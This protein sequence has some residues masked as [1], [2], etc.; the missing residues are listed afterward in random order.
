MLRV[1]TLHASSAA[2]TAMYYAQYL[3]AAPG[4]VP[5]M[6]VGQQAHRLGLTGDVTVK[7]LELLLSGRDPTSGTLLGRELLDRYRADGRVVRAVSG[8]DATFSAPKSVSVLWALT[9][10]QRFLE[11][12]DL[13]VAAALEHLERFGSTTRIRS[14]GARLHP[15]TNGL[16]LATFRQTT[17]RA[18][19]P[20]LHTH[21]VVSA[22]VQ[23]VDGRWWA[24]DARYLK[25]HQRM[26]GGLY[27]SVLRSELTAALGVEW[28]PIVNGQAD[29]AGVPDELLAVFSKR[30]AIIEHAMAVKLGEFRAR[31][32]R[33]PSRWERAVLEREASADT[34][35]RKTGHGA[36]DLVEHWRAEAEGVGWTASRL[37][38]AVEQAAQRTVPNKSISV[39]EVIEHLSTEHS[40]WGRA[41]VVRAVCDLLRPLP[42]VGGRRWAELVEQ[43]ADRVVGHCVDLDPTI[44]ARRRASDG[45]SVWIEPV[46][47]RFT[48]ET[49]LVEEE[50][51]TMWAIDAQQ[52][53]PN[54]STTVSATG[55]DVVQVDAAAA[56]AG[57]DRL[58]LVVGPAG[59]GKT[60]ALA[61][62]V[63]DLERQ[64]RVVFGVAPSAKAARVLADETRMPT[65]TVAKLLH[66]W[67]RADRHPDS[68]FLLPSGATL[69]VD[70]VGMISSPNL[71]RLVQLVE[72]N[73]WRVALVGDPR[74][75]QAVGRGG[76]FAELCANGRVIELEELHRFTHRWEAAASLQ[77][78]HGNPRAL[79]AYEAHGRIHAGTVEVH[80]DT[81]AAAWIDH[82]RH[83]DTIALVA[84]TNDHVDAI[85]RTVQQARLDTGHLDDNT[86]I[87]VAGGD[88]VFVGDVVATRRNDRQ[89]VTTTGEPVHN[90]DTWT[91]T[92]IGP[93][94]S[95]T[96]SHQRRH[97]TVT[98]PADYVNQHVWLGYAATEHGHQ[99]DTVTTAITL[100]TTTTTRRGLYVAATRGR[101]TN[102][103]CVVTDTSDIAE[104]R[105]I[106]DAVL[107]LDRAD[108][109]AITQRRT[110]ASISRAAT[111]TS[112]V[113]DLLSDLPTLPA[114]ET[115][116]ARPTGVEID[117]GIG[118]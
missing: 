38:G 73:Q 24:L 51:I 103:I 12:H 99:G 88:W 27:Q 90:R 70:E 7:Q 52:D 8:F 105:D 34:R 36:P 112:T 11:A 56:V 64:G 82:H 96:V 84:T 18:D 101:H 58:V 42:G 76:L 107:A 114:P 63:D 2:A 72:H 104:A 40:T 41:D 16:T 108:T 13:A 32:Q 5:G 61:A 77:L 6:W 110:L 33:E 37:W 54:P 17:S 102:H 23:T 48:S 45:R 10:D 3:T 22:K 98:L 25:R 97:G 80:L 66:E 86:A 53:I 19:D 69:V 94:G 115:R 71:S 50:A 117:L 59:A 20:Q 47:T 89:L 14:N 43:A 118:L 106:L 116:P 31:E 75:L 28:R 57:L 29:I 15:D 78:R 44:D 79:D 85:N 81:I 87:P 4:E 95:L 67:Q 21:A 39:A 49:I 111:P 26:L 113:D 46:A 92:H 35:G 91:V 93:D 68:T 65:A 109:P 55:L 1:T 100:A 30:T 9:G 60:S 74:Q 62:A 83:G